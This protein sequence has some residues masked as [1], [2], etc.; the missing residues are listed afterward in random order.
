MIQA[1]T[2]ERVSY[3]GKF[4]TFDDIPVIPKPHQKPHPPLSLVLRQSRGPSNWRPGA[5]GPC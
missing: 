2:Q 3:H 5:A 4:F 1:W